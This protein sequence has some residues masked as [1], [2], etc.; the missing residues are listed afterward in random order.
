MGR[1]AAG[2]GGGQLI[3]SS[4]K[5]SPS[6][7]AIHVGGESAQGSSRHKSRCQHPAA[8]LPF[9]SSP[10]RATA[11]SMVSGSVCSYRGIIGPMVAASGQPAKA[12][13]TTLVSALPAAVGR[14]LMRS[15][16][17]RQLSAPIVA[18]LPEVAA[19][20]LSA[21]V[22]PNPRP[23]LLDV[24]LVLDSRLESSAGK[25]QHEKTGLLLGKIDAAKNRR[26]RSQSPFSR[27]CSVG[28]RAVP[29]PETTV[30]QV[31]RLLSASCALR[32]A[33][34]RSRRLVSAPDE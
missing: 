2:S 28:I 12:P 30:N 11:K 26:E 5:L 24:G 29:E 23:A 27:P 19:L 16:R 1:R 22:R 18:L 10:M 7:G 13:G 3:T 6:G 4:S 17:R 8:R 9:C 25:T 33:D 32:K 34:R 14:R 15:S 31:S 20:S 21:G